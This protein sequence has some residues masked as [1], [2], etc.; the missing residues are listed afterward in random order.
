MIED[1]KEKLENT[2]YTFLEE[3]FWKD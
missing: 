3:R 1:L 2:E